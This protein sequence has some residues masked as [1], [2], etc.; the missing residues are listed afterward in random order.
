MTV[1]TTEKNELNE[2][3]ETLDQ[4][5]DLMEEQEVKDPERIK[6]E[7]TDLLVK[8]F[9]NKEI[10]K[11]KNEENKLVKEEIEELFRLPGEFTVGEDE[12]GNPKKVYFSKGNLWADWWK[13]L[14]F[15]NEQWEFEKTYEKDHVSHFTWS[16]DIASAVSDTC[17]GDFLFCDA[18][19]PIN[20]IGKTIIPDSYYALSI[21]EL[22]YLFD[23]ARMNVSGKKSYTYIPWSKNYKIE[24][25][26]CEGIF[27][28]PD[29]YDGEEIGKEG[30]P[31]T[32]AAINS[33]G[34]VY[35]PCAGSREGTSAGNNSTYYWS[36]S[37]HEDLTDSAYYML[38]NEF[39]G[40]KTDGF[41]QKKY[42]YSLRLVTNVR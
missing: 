1:E 18:E 15:E 14:Y 7:L 34:I 22:R 40:L 35:L 30:A 36:S 26:R 39:K 42:G 25:Q 4:E 9:M 37:F 3:K 8:Y 23:D 13:D 24:D 27:V 21:E 10:V 29:N 16:S 6:A 33:R 38:C 5:M 41:N 28:Y 12:N 32:W 17:G 31:Y 11:E 20:M 19:H 2:L